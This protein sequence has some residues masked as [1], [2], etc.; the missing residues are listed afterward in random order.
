M[1]QIPEFLYNQKNIIYIDLSKNPIEDI[2]QKVREHF[3]GA[4]IQLSTKDDARGRARIH[5]K[6]IGTMLKSG[7][8]III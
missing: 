3:P 7:L 1:T 5:N 2:R 8:L 4:T 6:K